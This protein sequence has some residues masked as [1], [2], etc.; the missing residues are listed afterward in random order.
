MVAQRDIRAKTARKD[1]LFSLYMIGNWQSN[2]RKKLNG[3]R[4]NF[5]P[6]EDLN[7]LETII[8][9]FF[10]Q[11]RIHF[12]S[13]TYKKKF[14]GCIKFFTGRQL[15]MNNLRRAKKWGEPSMTALTLLGGSLNISL[16]P[17]NNV[18]A[19]VE[20]APRTLNLTEWTTTVNGDTQVITDYTGDQ[21]NVVIPLSGDLGWP[22]VKITKK[23]LRK[24]ASSANNPSGALT[25]SHHDTS[26][27]GLI[28]D[29]SGDKDPSDTLVDYSETF[30]SAKSY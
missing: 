2:V 7:M 28:S 10:K 24:A 18:Q 8:Y 19:L 30:H 1:S 22:N 25:T 12:L 9:T 5:Y 15:L 4:N 14:S 23:V 29:N 26:G 6:S 16:V 21:K 11:V 13:D 3:M 17:T 20:E 27:K